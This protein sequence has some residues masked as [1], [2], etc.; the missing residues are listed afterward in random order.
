MHST[1][2]LLNST[3]DKY[4][5]GIGNGSDVIGKYLCEQ[6]RTEARAFLPELFGRETTNDDGI[7]GEHIY[8]PRFNH[9]GRKRDYLRGFGIQFWGIGCQPTATNFAWSVPGFG[10]S[11][12]KEIK[13]RY[14]AWIEVHPF[15]EVLPRRDNYVTVKDTPNDQYG[16][17]LPRIVYSTGENERMMVKEMYDTLEMLLHEAKAEVFELQRGRTGRNGSAIHEHGT[18]RMGDDPKRS[19]LNKFNQMH[20]VRNLFV[21]DGSAFP[22]AT[23]KNPT[24]TIL[25]LAWRATDY[26]CDQLKRG[27]LG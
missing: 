27:R 15:G 4:A 5:N 24:L 3:S 20:E 17:P 10:S 8:M 9:R 18:C 14:P 6:V 25:A 7:G 13:R 12:K 26:L 11:L 21:V 16:V 22:T 1:R 19:A 23:E 2:I